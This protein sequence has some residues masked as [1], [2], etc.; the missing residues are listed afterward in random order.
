MDNQLCACELSRS[1]RS[2]RGRARLPG[3]RA[4]RPGDFIVVNIAIHSICN[5]RNQNNTRMVL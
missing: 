4:L 1:I 3:P 5:R 2:W